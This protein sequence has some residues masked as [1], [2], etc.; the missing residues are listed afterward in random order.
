MSRYRGDYNPLTNS[1]H[2][3]DKTQKQA[4]GNIAYKEREKAFQEAIAKAN[5]V[6]QLYNIKKV[7][8]IGIL[9]WDLKKHKVFKRRTKK[10][11]EEY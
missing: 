5:E 11:L 6:L 1:G 3:P 4:I 7:E 9:C 2:C 8:A 10:F